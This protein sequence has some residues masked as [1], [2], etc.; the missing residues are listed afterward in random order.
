[1]ERAGD[2]MRVAP[3]LLHM[4]IRLRRG[5]VSLCVAA[6]S[7]RQVHPSKHRMQMSVKQM[8][9]DGCRVPVVAAAET[10][11]GADRQRRILSS[12]CKRSSSDD[13]DIDGGVRITLASVC[14]DDENL[15]TG[16]NAASGVGSIHSRCHVA[17][18]WKWSN[19]ACLVN[20]ANNLLQNCRERDVGQDTEATYVY[21]I[22]G[23]D[24][25]F[26]KE[27]EDHERQLTA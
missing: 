11:L 20:E 3:N 2:C 18:Y 10:G 7:W 22:I 17:I 8:Q 24:T 5:H 21:Q 4:R 6:K 19:D 13:G 12:A 15:A 9:R 25:C 23:R 27:K 1:M 16:A 14:R 26:Q